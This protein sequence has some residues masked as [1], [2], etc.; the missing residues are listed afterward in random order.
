[1]SA[2]RRQRVVPLLFYSCLSRV[3]RSDHTP[4]HVCHL[5]PHALLRSLSAVEVVHRS[6]SCVSALS[7]NMRSVYLFGPSMVSLNAFKEKQAGVG[8]YVCSERVVPFMSRS[9][10]VHSMIV[11]HHSSDAHVPAPTTD[12]VISEDGSTDEEPLARVEPTLDDVDRSIPQVD[13]AF[14]ANLIQARR[15]RRDEFL[16]RKQVIQQRVQ[17]LTRESTASV[18]D[19][20][21]LIRVGGLGSGGRIVGVDSDEEGVLTE[22]MGAFVPHSSSHRRAVS[23]A[24]CETA[25]DDGASALPLAATPSGGSVMAPALVSMHALAQLSEDEKD[26]LY[27]TRPEYDD[28]FVL[29]DCRT[30]NEVT[31]WGILEGAKV[32]PAHEFFDAFRASPEDFRLEYGFAKPRPEQMVICYCQY[33]PRSLMAAQILSWMGYPKV[34]HFRDGYYE[35]GKQYNLLLRR[36][37]EHDR[38]SGNELRRLA[39]FQAGL[40]MQRAIASEFNALPMQEAAQYRI[41]VTRSPGKLKIG[42]GVRAEAYEQLMK[43]SDEP[44]PIGSTASS[45]SLRDM[46]DSGTA[47]GEL[48]SIGA[49]GVDGPDMNVLPVALLEESTNEPLQQFFRHATGV[50]MEMQEDVSSIEEAIDVS[51]TAKSTPTSHYSG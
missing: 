38:D 51:H 18:Q 37:M 26:A 41:D 44:L 21:E 2:M 8:A 33:G 45:H 35:W 46:I 24:S 31:S 48:S 32:L 49:A 11:D 16:R 3:P 13:C 6:L 42:E 39:A 7:K 40:E 23:C 34:M 22:G 36:W 9:A 14:M 17:C 5:E 30:V 4:R 20:S 28:G 50:S 10:G 25:V 12:H 15:S 19:M 29:L 1:M 27:T 43:I 47:G